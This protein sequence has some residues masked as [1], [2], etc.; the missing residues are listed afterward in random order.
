[1][2]SQAYF[3]NAGAFLINAVFGLYIFAVLLR[4]LF[5]LV[6]A[7]FY[8]PLCQ[9]IVAV[10]NPPLKRLRRVIPAFGR[11][12]SSSVLLLIVLQTINTFLLASLVGASVALPGLVV[13]AMAELISKTLWV[14]LGA[15]FIQ[16]IT[17]W[18]APGAY[19]PILSV[20]DAL[21][22]PL[23]KPARRLIPPLGPLDLSPMV[24]IIGLQLAQ[25]VL[26]A[27]IRDIGLALL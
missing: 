16:V 8:N 14:F 19:N 23:M 3:S 17:S 6:Q 24:V 12:D 10:T 25:I 9:A 5:Q 22:A 21:C 7:D 26:V 4:L 2:G 20:V 15:I 18:V 11:M 1:M 13:V 27:P